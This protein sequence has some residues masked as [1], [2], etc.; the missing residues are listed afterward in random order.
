MNVQVRLI[1]YQDRTYKFYLRSPAASWFLKRTARVHT[2][3][4]ALPE[5]TGNVRLKEIFH[6]AKA[7]SCDP[8]YI[9]VPLKQICQSLMGSARSL[10]LQV[11]DDQLD[12]QFKNRDDVQ[13]ADLDRLKREARLARKNAGRRGK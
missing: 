8:E 2:G 11:V 3:K 7:K 10:G 9:G 4:G 6:I 1:V 5:V 12:P 13:P